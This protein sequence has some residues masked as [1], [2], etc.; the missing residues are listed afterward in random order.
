MK[1]FHHPT[2]AIGPREGRRGG[3]ME[4]AALPVQLSSLWNLTYKPFS[5]SD[6]PTKSEVILGRSLT[7]IKR[8]FRWHLHKCL[9]RTSLSRRSN[10]TVFTS[11]S[12]IKLDVIFFGTCAK[13][14]LLSSAAC[15]ETLKTRDRFQHHLA[16]DTLIRISSPPRPALAL[17]PGRHEWSLRIWYKTFHSLARV[18]NRLIY[19]TVVKT[20]LPFLL[21]FWG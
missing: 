5:T 17:G 16:R 15:R 11:S 9:L 2:F 12:A 14:H 21:N 10:S 19:L 3:A 6:T 1:N 8:V 13:Y 4:W 20:F 18:R 7:L